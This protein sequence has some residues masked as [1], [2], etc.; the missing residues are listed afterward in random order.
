MNANRFFSISCRSIVLFFLVAAR[1]PCADPCLPPLTNAIKKLGGKISIY[2]NEKKNP[3]K[4]EENPSF[5][6]FFVNS[7]LTDLDLLNL[8]PDL[9]Q[10]KNFKKL[11]LR[12]TKV[13]GLYLNEFACFPDLKEIDLSSTPIHDAG[14]RTVAS[15]ANVERLHLNQTHLS[16]D[17]LNYLMKQAGPRLT[18]LH[19]SN[20]AVVDCR[21]ILLPRKCILK[22][23]AT[24]SKL[25]ELSLSGMQLKDKHIPALTAFPILS[26]LDLSANKLTNDGLK[27]LAELDN[28]KMLTDLNVSDNREV[29]DAGVMEICKFIKLTK[30]NISGTGHPE[31]P[32]STVTNLSTRRLLLNLAELE[33][34]R[35][36][37]TNTFPAR[38]LVPA[39]ISASLIS[40]PFKNLKT[41]DISSTGVSDDTLRVVADMFPYLNE[42]DLSNTC[43]HDKGLENLA[44]LQGPVVGIVISGTKATTAGLTLLQTLM[45][46]GPVNGKALQPRSPVRVESRSSLRP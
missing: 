42:L 30:L 37:N 33:T 31:K 18:A 21:M 8:V 45:A 24:C 38:V 22:A 17:G 46:S 36:G 16:E 28:L 9:A 13:E 26:K 23:L 15:L 1:S 10:I 6:V 7:Y 11:D 39:P 12:G 29:T 32:G 44:G 20:A 14:L 4:K 27:K 2:A 25:E 35:I 5:T 19:L 41:L 34:F 3:P 40:I 43:I